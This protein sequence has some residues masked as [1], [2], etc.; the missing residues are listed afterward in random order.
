MGMVVE[1]GCERAGVGRRA[2]SRALCGAAGNDA[3]WRG[4]VCVRAAGNRGDAD[5]ARACYAAGFGWGLG[6]STFTREAVVPRTTFRI[7]QTTCAEFAGVMRRVTLPLA[8][9][10][11][12]TRTSELGTKISLTRRDSS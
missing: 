3:D 1:C 7:L 2:C 10:P 9:I 8:S 6:V 4:T 11:A 12:K 5:G